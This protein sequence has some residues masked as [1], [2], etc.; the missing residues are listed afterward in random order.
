MR[1]TAYPLTHPHAFAEE[2]ALPFLTACDGM[3]PFAGI[4]NEHEVTDAVARA[5]G[6][7]VW[8]EQPPPDASSD[9]EARILVLSAAP[10]AAWVAMGGHLLAQRGATRPLYVSCFTSVAYSDGSAVRATPF[11]AAMTARD[12]GA[13]CAG[14]TGTETCFL[15]IPDRAS[16]AALA[17]ANFEE[18]ELPVRASVRLM[19][20]HLITTERPTD[21][22]APAA[23]TNDPDQRLLFEIVLE[24]FEDAFFAGTR[25]HLYEDVPAAGIQVDDFLARF[26]SSYLDV[27]PWTA[28]V[29]GHLE[30]KAALVDAFRST[31]GPM[32][33]AA[34]RRAAARNAMWNG[35]AAAAHERFWTLRL[36]MPDPEGL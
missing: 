32:E 21:V 15:D 19:L 9:A 5:L 6:E 31:C 33:E 27:A 2:E 10:H 12:E 22:F 1:A 18:S 23:L 20:Q 3:T 29:S 34:L 25:F 35:D 30:Q 28:D 36:T 11:E 14:I 26:E 7:V 4:L 16:R 17:P 24:I 13:F 8:L